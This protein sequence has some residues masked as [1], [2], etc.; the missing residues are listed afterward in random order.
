MK[1]ISFCTLI[2]FCE[3]KSLSLLTLCIKS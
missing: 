2:Y 3:N 1:S